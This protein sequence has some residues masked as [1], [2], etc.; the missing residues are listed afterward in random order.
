MSSMLPDIIQDISVRH[1]IKGFNVAIE[2][3][4]ELWKVAWQTFLKI[5]WIYA[6]LV[7][8]PYACQISETEELWGKAAILLP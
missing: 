2:I 5:V 7:R 1:S 8:L 4:S 3:C 6:F